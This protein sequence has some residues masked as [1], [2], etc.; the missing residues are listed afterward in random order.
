VR[1]ADTLAIWDAFPV[2]PLHVLVVPRRHVSDPFMLSEIERRACFE[3]VSDV[4]RLLRERDP[5]IRGF[6]VGVNVGATA[7]QTVSHCHI[8]VIP[9]RQGDVADP[10]GGVRN[11]IPGRGRYPGTP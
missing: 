8:H 5:S 2:T 4:V 9:R 3:L 10:V 1:S 11:V 7:G 6:N